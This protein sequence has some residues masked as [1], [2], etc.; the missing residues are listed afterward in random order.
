MSGSETFALK[1]TAEDLASA[2]FAML[3]ANI[4]SAEKK[5]KLMAATSG[6]TVQTIGTLAASIRQMRE[7]M[8]LGGEASWMRRSATRS[9]EFR[10]R[11]KESSERVGRIGE[12]M[13]NLMPAFEG[14]TA[15]A[16]AGGLAAALHVGDETVEKFAS[17]AKNAKSIGMSMGS[18][19][20]YQNFAK[21]MDV[22]PARFTAEAQRMQKNIAA[23][24]QGH[25]PQLV[26]YFNQL[27]VPI[28]KNGHVLPVE[29]ILQ[30]LPLVYQKNKRSADTAQF[31]AALAGRNGGVDI[32]AMFRLPP[33]ERDALMS[34]VK[35]ATYTPSPERQD[36]IEHAN[37]ANKLFGMAVDSLKDKYGAIVGTTLAPL[38]EWATGF[39]DQHRDTI[40]KGAAIAT[41]F[42]VGGSGYALYRSGKWLTDLFKGRAAI[43]G[44]ESAAGAPALASGA[45]AG[46][47]AAAAEG[48]AVASAAAGGGAELAGAGLG[49][50]AG[51]G[52]GALGLGAAAAAMATATGVLLYIG[53]EAAR[54]GGEQKLQALNRRNRIAADTYG[55][56]PLDGYDAAGNRLP[57]PMQ[58]APFIPPYLLGG[59]GQGS[60]DREPPAGHIVVDFQN[61]P[62][63]TTATISRQDGMT[64]DTRINGDTGRRMYSGGM[65]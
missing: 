22:D 20:I 55:Q 4:D 28:V 62:P 38:K 10:D 40:A 41:P 29:Q 26:K 32:E 46:G 50:G 30:L 16:G 56:V 42:G 60:Q 8:K 13:T 49:A 25:N 63:G 23:A 53:S 15:L 47:A 18:L 45:S 52:V 2:K 64:I 17:L 21:L 24:A 7:E 37:Q 61:A 27:G 6:S 54:Q 5:M 19:Q 57:M 12:G 51:V 65:P 34:K 14:I 44:G 59:G 1:L 35:A 11:L 9:A 3:K 31:S 48:G 43:A 58:M 36:A 39:L 33:E